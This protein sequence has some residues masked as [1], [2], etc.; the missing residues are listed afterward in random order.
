MPPIPESSVHRVGCLAVST[1]FEG[2]LPESWSS[3]LHALSVE[4][5]ERIESKGE[6]SGD[7][8]GTG[9]ST[10][11]SKA[12]TKLTTTLRSCS[13]SRWW[14]AKSASAWHDRVNVS[15]SSRMTGVSIL[16]LSRERRKFGERKRG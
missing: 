11:S 16:R 13:V 12:R 6:S 7:S 1:S 8:K 15:T 5:L 2:E 9:G 4:A 10:S 14:C 3:S